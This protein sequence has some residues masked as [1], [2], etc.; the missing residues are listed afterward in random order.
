MIKF[1]RH[2]IKHTIEREIQKIYF[3]KDQK[4]RFYKFW[5]S[6]CILQKYFKNA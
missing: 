5:A 1:H 4:A 3:Q 6:V 2:A